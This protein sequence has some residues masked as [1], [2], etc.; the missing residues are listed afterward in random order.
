MVKKHGWPGRQ[1]QPPDAGERRW[2]MLS[3]WK[4]SKETRLVDAATREVRFE[5]REGGNG[6]AGM[7]PARLT[8]GR[9]GMGR[10]VGGRI[11]AMHELN[12]RCDELGREI[13]RQ[14]GLKIS[15]RTHAACAHDALFFEL[16]CFS[17]PSWTLD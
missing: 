13:S 7:L 9:R 8:G 11:R 1:I 16:V 17:L 4:C 10:P 12:H 15:P 2:V 5:P 14:Q 6:L 3:F